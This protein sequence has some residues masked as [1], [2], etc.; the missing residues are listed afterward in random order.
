VD[1]T[2]SAA[3]FCLHEE[4]HRTQFT[5]VDWLAASV[6]DQETQ[7]LLA[8][9][10]RPGDHSGPGGGR[11]RCH[12]RGGAGGDGDSLIEAIQTRA[13]EEISTASPA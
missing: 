2:T 8:S 4:T 9:D 6:Q 11:R 10:L 1:R 5:S 13:S 12:G 3:G 7:F